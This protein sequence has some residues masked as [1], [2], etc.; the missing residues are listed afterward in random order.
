MT[1]IDITK[2]PETLREMMKKSGYNGRTL[3]KVSGFREETVSR[4]LNWKLSITTPNL[5]KIITILK[6]KSKE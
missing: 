2:I 6:T 1:N 3:S 5:I 4:W